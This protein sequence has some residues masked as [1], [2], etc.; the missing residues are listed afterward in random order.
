MENTRK[1]HQCTDGLLSHS[2]SMKLNHFIL[3]CFDSFFPSRFHY[4]CW[5]NWYTYHILSLYVSLGFHCD[6]RYNFKFHQCVE[7]KMKW[8]KHEIIHKIL[9]NT[10]SKI[11]FIIANFLLT[12]SQTIKW[13]KNSSKCHLCSLLPIQILSNQL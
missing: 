13:N 1:I 10:L 3:F 11:W 4:V 9:T 8:K 2:R 5:I 12:V 7:F 6:F